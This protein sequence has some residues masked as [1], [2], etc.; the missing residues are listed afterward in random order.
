MGALLARSLTAAGMKVVVYDIDEK[1]AVKA[2]R[3]LGV[4]Y[5]GPESVALGDIVVVSVPVEDT[6]K[7]CLSTAMEMRQ[8]SLLVE[9][10]SV[11]TSVVEKIKAGVSDAIEYASMHP[12]FGPEARSVKGR[13]VVLIPV[14]LER[15]RRPLCNLMGRM[16][17]KIVFS[18]VEGHDRAM[19]VVQ[20]L[21]HFSY[22]CLASCISQLVA[23]MRFCTRS[24]EETLRTLRR[25]NRNLG[26][27]L[28]IQRENPFAAEVRK[29]YSASVLRLAEDQRNF[30]EIV[31]ECFGK[32]FPEI[33]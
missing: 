26:V 6:V 29:A 25:I 1:K 19:A 14:R 4:R 7:V 8:G 12:L 9:I 18:D 20:V 33:V 24:F 31:R 5:G 27:I 28:S 16:G 17:W 32:L 23:D 10:S 22:L 11:K 21:H 30:E 2:A 15:W 3:R 13:A